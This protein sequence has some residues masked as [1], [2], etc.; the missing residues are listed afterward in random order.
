MKLFD[1]KRFENPGVLTPST[2]LLGSTVGAW[3]R[4]FTMG[5][6]EKVRAE[7]LAAR[8]NGYTYEAAV[9][10]VKDLKIKSQDVESNV[11]EPQKLDYL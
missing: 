9:Q 4:A 2:P 11:S 6:A 10:A 1:F 3:E 8:R 5:F 7:E